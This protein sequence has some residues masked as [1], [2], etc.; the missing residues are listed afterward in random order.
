M[1]GEHH[2]MIAK[3]RLILF[4]ADFPGRKKYSFLKINT[5]WW[6]RNNYSH[7][8]IFAVSAQY[9]QL[10]H[11]LKFRPEE[12]TW[13]Y[14]VNELSLKKNYLQCFD[15]SFVKLPFIQC[16]CYSL[17]TLLNVF[18]F[19]TIFS[20]SINSYQYPP[21]PYASSSLDRI[22]ACVVEYPHACSVIRTPNKK[23]GP[24]KSQKNFKEGNFRSV[25][26]PTSPPPLWAK[27]PSRKLLRGI[28]YFNT[29]PNFTLS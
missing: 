12:I 11:L 14:D 9:M 22:C 7:I 20:N 25:V 10:F 19:D 24:T 17:Y 1:Q 2:I 26:N 16:L 29:L 21:L 27:L 18:N 23:C 8:L 3:S 6:C 4:F 28:A 5:I 13:V 15:F